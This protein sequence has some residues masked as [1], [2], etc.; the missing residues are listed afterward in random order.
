MNKNNIKI[1]SRNTSLG[2]AFGER[3]NR[4]IRYLL[5][6]PVF[7]KGYGNWID[8]LPTI[9]KQNNNRIHSS[10]KLPPNQA[11]LRENKEYAFK[12]L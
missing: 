1:Y 3:F 7:D 10:T 11:S 6:R 5:K 12:N 2:D 9:T 4:T 8:V